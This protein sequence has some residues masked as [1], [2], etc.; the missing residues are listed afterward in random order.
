MADIASHRSAPGFAAN[1]AEIFHTLAR[2]LFDPY[3]PEHHYMRGPG[4]KWRAK[5]R[6]AA[7]KSVL[8]PALAKVR[9]ASPFGAGPT[10]SA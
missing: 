6:P 8:A 5:H 9:A 10:A 4:P 1:L 2:D 7:T 3:R